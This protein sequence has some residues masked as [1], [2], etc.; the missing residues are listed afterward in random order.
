MKRVLQVLSSLNINSGIANV[1]M[2]WYR[3]IDREEVQF[4]FLIL[5][6]MEKTYEEEVK[7]M[8]AKVF[9]FPHP[10]VKTL[11]KFKRELSDFFKENGDYDIIHCHEITIAGMLFRAA[12]GTGAKKVLHVHNTKYS[13][14]PL[15][16]VRNALFSVSGKKRA[17]YKVACGKLAGEKLY[18]KRAKFSVIL[19]PVSRDRLVTPSEEEK[20][21][22]RAE[23]GI[24][25]NSFVIG[26]VARLSKEKNQKF[27]LKLMPSVLKK[28]PDA[29]LLSVGAGNS[30]EELEKYA[31]KLKIEKNVIFAGAR[32]DISAVLS[33]MDVFAFPSKF[34]GLP[35]SVVEAEYMGLP[36]LCSNKITEEC[37]PD[38]DDFLP[39]KKKVWVK[40]VFAEKKEL[41]ENWIDKFFAENIVEELIKF[42]NEIR[43]PLLTENGSEK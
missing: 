11:F 28:N 5:W 21:A 27:L 41:P 2:N 35:L 30:R 19:N 40:R 25:E 22:L 8:G 15:K 38:K 10:T 39:L 7:S 33:V 17:D 20:N 37:S 1:V 4:D 13:V 29:L 18:G 32:R 12:K 16:D 14:N 31:R 43:E 6:Q 42:Y 3:G 9:Y 36:V 23:F 26:N 34:E 24:A